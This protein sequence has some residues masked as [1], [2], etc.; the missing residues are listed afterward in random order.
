M[1]TLEQ[2]VRA[3]EQEWEELWRQGPTRVRW[4]TLPPQAGD[5]APDLELVDSEG[6]AARLS[7]FWREQPALLI[8]W[9]HYGCNCGFDRARRLYR[10]HRD[11]V[12]AG[13]NVV[14]IGQGEPARARAYARMHEVPCPVLCDPTFAAYE[15]YGLLE[16]KPSQIV[17][18]APPEFLARDAAAAAGLAA[19]R[20]EAGTPL[21]DS[22]WQ[23]PGEFVVARGGI[24]ELAYRYQYCD[25]FPDP[26]VLLAAIEE[27]NT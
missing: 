8:F 2:Q 25:N 3:A 20:R 21:V 7:D 11:Y 17:Y 6:A 5:S 4:E 10:E 9:R 26:R 1:A 12:G 19:E 27:A 15:A 16:G 23:L 22:P 18:D 14:A 24:I 13:A